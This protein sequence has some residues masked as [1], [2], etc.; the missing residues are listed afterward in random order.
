MPEKGIKTYW[1]TRY[2]SAQKTTEQQTQ[3]KQQQTT[4]NNNR[5]HTEMEAEIEIHEQ[6]GAEGQNIQERGLPPQQLN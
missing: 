5:K 6:A 2:A 4:T 3:Y 1:N